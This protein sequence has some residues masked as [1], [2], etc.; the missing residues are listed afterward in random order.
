M[1]RSRRSRRFL[2]P[3]EAAGRPSRVIGK[4]NL[5]R[6]AGTPLTKTQ[7][8]A[9]AKAEPKGKGKVIDSLL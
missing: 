8:Q 2:A 6:L 9:I 4:D 1:I 7:H 3:P 5:K